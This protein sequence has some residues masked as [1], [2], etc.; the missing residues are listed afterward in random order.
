[1][2][3][4]ICPIMS[5][6]IKEIYNTTTGKSSFEGFVQCQEEKCALW[7]KIKC[8]SKNYKANSEGCG[9]GFNCYVYSQ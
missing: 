4:K 6:Q 7:V 8:D 5:N 2:E 3:G 9:L 1:M